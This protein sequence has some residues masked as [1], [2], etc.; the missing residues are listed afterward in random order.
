[1]FPLDLYLVNFNVAL[2]YLYFRYCT[3][4]NVRTLTISSCFCLC[5]GVLFREQIAELEKRLEVVQKEKAELEEKVGILEQQGA[6]DPR[7]TRVVRLA[8]SNPFDRAQQVE[9][10]RLEEVLYPYTSSSSLHHVCREGFFYILI[11]F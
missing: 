4:D 5:S 1:M 11:L 8:F 9:N 10:K 3:V 7:S 2:P 6:F